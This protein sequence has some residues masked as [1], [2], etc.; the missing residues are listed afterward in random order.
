[1]ETFLCWLRSRVS[2]LLWFFLFCQES[3]GKA[4]SLGGLTLGRGIG[5]GFTLKPALLQHN[6]GFYGHYRGQFRSDSAREYRL[7]A[8]PQ[9]P[10]VFLQRCQVG[11]SPAGSWATFCC[12]LAAR[13]TSSA[14][15]QLN[16]HPRPAYPQDLHESWALVPEMSYLPPTDRVYKSRYRGGQCCSL[17]L[18]NGGRIR[19][20]VGWVIME[21]EPPEP[22]KYAL[23]FADNCPSAWIPWCPKSQWSSS[24]SASS[25][26]GSG[27]RRKPPLVRRT[28][29]KVACIHPHGLP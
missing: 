16:W 19:A 8:K 10:A 24:Q 13:T 17:L 28:A 6:S 1:M 20:K 2:L 12:S 18:L 9:P 29:W 25:S 26:R 22:K 23:S 3:P 14:Q 27:V 11:S 15:P 21:W 7:A 5:V 4:S